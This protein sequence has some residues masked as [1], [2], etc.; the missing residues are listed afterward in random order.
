MFDWLICLET[1]CYFK[2]Y[3]WGYI[4]GIW[5]DTLSY[6]MFAYVIE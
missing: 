2:V 5:Q 3:M 6:E 1:F 4:L